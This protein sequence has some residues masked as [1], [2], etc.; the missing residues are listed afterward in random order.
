ATQR[1]V[2]HQ[3]GG[4]SE[5][6]GARRCVGAGFRSGQLLGGGGHRASLIRCK[7]MFTCQDTAGHDGKSTVV[8]ITCRTNYRGYRRKETMTRTPGPG[9]AAAS[10]DPG[11][12]VA[13]PR[14]RDAATTRQLLLDAARQRF[15]I[16][17]YAATSVR[18]IAHD[19]GV[20]VAL[21]N[22]YFTSK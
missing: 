14:R 6:A 7:R 1:Q 15:A 21:I 10:P 12:A 19:A 16:D 20:N 11:G 13:G 5:A 22:R 9:L 18:D 2:E 17:G 8:Y 3:E 4:V